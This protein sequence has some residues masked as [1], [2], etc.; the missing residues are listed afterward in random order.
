MH[1]TS[2]IPLNELIQ[3]QHE[4]KARQDAIQL[5]LQST[6][7]VT[8]LLELSRSLRSVSDQFRVIAEKI[9]AESSERRMRIQA[10]LDKQANSAPHETRHAA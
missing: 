2:A 8:A 1:T 9:R 10:F 7:D 6:K 5:A 3:R 4:L